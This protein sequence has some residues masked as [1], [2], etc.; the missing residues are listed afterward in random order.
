MIA[1]VLVAT[2]A[3]LLAG[4]TLWRARGAERGRVVPAERSAAVETQ[5]SAIRIDSFPTAETASDLSAQ[6]AA[7]V[8]RLGAGA[9]LGGERIGD[10]AAAFRERL[11]AT[12]SP[13]RSRDFE[14]RIRRGAKLVV[15]EP[16]PAQMNA[17]EAERAGGLLAP[18]GLDQMEVR[19]LYRQG[20]AVAAPAEGFRTMRFTTK[21]PARMDIPEDP[22]QAR[23]DVVEVRLP[24][25]LRDV[26][27]EVHDV[28]VGYQFGWNAGRRQWIP[29][30]N[31]V[32]ADP[33]L[34]FAALPF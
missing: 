18:L 17:W 21:G 24:M 28:L 10:L 7:V 31:V 27:G 2:V 6:A 4:R 32:Y 19:V 8:A 3:L 29:F 30:A 1:V 15:S 20:K 9:G 16:T 22:V 25:R 12:I 11:A 5:L 23:L 26:Q 34:V 33:A 14:A 13:D